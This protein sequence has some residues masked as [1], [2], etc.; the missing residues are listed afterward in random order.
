MI[1]QHERCL[2]RV[3][4]SAPRHCGLPVGGYWGLY[5]GAYLQVFHYF[6]ADTAH[7]PR[8]IDVLQH[9]RRQ[10]D[11]HDQEIRYGQIDDKVVGH[12][13][14]ALVPP[15][16]EADEEVAD[17]ADDEDERIG[18]DQAPFERAREQVIHYHV[19]VLVVRHAVLVRAEHRRR[20]GSRHVPVERD[21]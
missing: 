19:H 17:D 13:A 2:V 16:R 8:L 4:W 14:H 10:T 6:T 12:S 18:G 7:V 15:H 21:V 9:R 1:W 20:V 11:Q 5:R 3:P